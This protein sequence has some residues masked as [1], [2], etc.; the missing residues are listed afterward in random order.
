MTADTWC[1]SASRDQPLALSQTLLKPRI[2][3]FS[4]EPSVV[5]GWIAQFI[6][7]LCDEEWRDYLSVSLSALVCPPWGLLPAVSQSDDSHRPWA[8]WTHREQ[9]IPTWAVS[10]KSK[11]YVPYETAVSKAIHQLKEECRLAQ[12]FGCWVSDVRDRAALPLLWCGNTAGE[13]TLFILTARWGQTPCSL[14]NT[15]WTRGFEDDGEYTHS[16]LENEW[17][18]FY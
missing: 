4:P 8:A 10:G 14:S 11:A 7:S 17:W 13:K 12:R 5:T 18:C 16:Y 15:W 3:Y 9:H 6:L 2:N 1:H